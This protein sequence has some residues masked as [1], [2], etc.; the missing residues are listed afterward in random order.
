MNPFDGAPLRVP[1]RPDP[2]PIDECKCNWGVAEGGVWLFTTPAMVEIAEMLERIADAL[3]EGGDRQ[4]G[5]LPCEWTDE[6][7]APTAAVLREACDWITTFHAS[8]GL[9]PEEVIT[10]WK[11]FLPDHAYIVAAWDVVDGKRVPPEGWSDEDWKEEYDR[12]L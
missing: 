6:H 7:G 8:T 1:P 9:T 10:E 12:P 2:R 4:L 5:H 3:I 11:A